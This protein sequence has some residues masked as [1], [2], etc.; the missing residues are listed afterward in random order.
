MLSDGLGRPIFSDDKTPIQE[1]QKI[2]GIMPIQILEHTIIREDLHLAVREN[3]NE[4]V[5]GP[6][7]ARSALANSRCRGAPVMAIGNI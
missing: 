1:P 6:A 7:L 2:R 5:R 3:D 4:E